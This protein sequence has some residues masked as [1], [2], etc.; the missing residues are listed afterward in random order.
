MTA[1]SSDS[2]LDEIFDLYR[3]A[4]K[5]GESSGSDYATVAA[6]AEFAAKA[7]LLAWNKQ[8]VEA[9]LQKATT[10][11][12][13]YAGTFGRDANGFELGHQCRCGY[14]SR[15]KSSI[16]G[17]VEWKKSELTTRAESQGDE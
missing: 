6:A 4:I 7:A 12:H 1:P 5:Q 10:Q 11:E 8:R 14:R 17:H 13:W 16:D 2:E 3:G 15:S 9:A